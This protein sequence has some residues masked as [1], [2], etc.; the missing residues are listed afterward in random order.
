MYLD[1]LGFDEGQENL[2]KFIG[3][4]FRNWIFTFLEHGYHVLCNHFTGRDR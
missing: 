4:Y 3:Q 2:N 1:A